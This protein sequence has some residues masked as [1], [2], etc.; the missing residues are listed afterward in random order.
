M[1]NA[2]TS[3]S[4]KTSSFK[5][6]SYN[7]ILLFHLYTCINFIY[8]S[9]GSHNTACNHMS[10]CI[11]A[12]SGKPEMRRVWHFY[13]WKGKIMAEA[14]N[15]TLIR[16]R[17]RCTALGLVIM[18]S[19]HNWETRLTSGYLELSRLNIKEGHCSVFTGPCDTMS[20]TDGKL[21]Y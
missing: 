15:G 2:I 17:P 6:H 14:A 3:H 12:L 16:A 9:C 1:P 7:Y 18:Y 21:H 10:A 8:S 5:S 20:W 4:D 19:C 13:L 11:L